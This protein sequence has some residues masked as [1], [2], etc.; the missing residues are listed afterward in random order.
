MKAFYT[1]VLMVLL[2]SAL[3]RAQALEVPVFH[4]FTGTV[5]LTAE[6]GPNVSYTDYKFEPLQID[7]TARAS[8]E[9]FFP[10][11]AKS[12]FG[13]RAFGEGGYTR[14]KDDIRTPTKFRTS[15]ISAGGGLVYGL[16]INEVVFP[17]L[18]AGGSYDWFT[19]KDDNGN[20]LSVPDKQQ[21]SGIGEL[22]FRFAIA[23][24]MSV[25]IAG[26]IHLGQKDYLDG[27]KHGS[28]NDA[29]F[30]GMVGLSIALNASKDTDHD[31]IPDDKDKCPDTPIGVR[32]DENGCPP[33]FDHDGV[34]D[35]RDKCSLTP[36]GV[37]VDENGCPLDSD[38]DGVPDYID[39]CP[40]TAAGIVVDEYGCPKDADGDGVPDYLDQCPNT[41][42]G[43]AVDMHGCPLDS[44][45]DKVPDYKDKCPN[46]PPGVQVDEFG[47][48]LVKEKVEVIREVPV[49]KEV[50]VEKEI[51]LSAGTSFATGKSV[52]LK[53]ASAVLD[54]LVTIMKENQQS[55]WII[56]GHTDNVGAKEKNKKLSLARAQAVQK[57]FVS[58]GIQK[59]RFTVRGLGSD[60]PI[61]NN[62]TEDGRSQNRRVSIIRVK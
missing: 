45:G 41:P 19:P 54:Q 44:D 12:I 15:I 5:V 25:N 1:F 13:L 57:Y 62:N 10:F 17:Y 2:T 33:D 31:G 20:S 6:A 48:P 23:Y 9:Y 28:Q 24:N 59:D 50:P 60:F 38:H 4:P 53:A 39:M 35:Y 22:G 21:F 30:S 29:Y 42:K 37:K 26:S 11:H 51:V 58:K 52:L 32:A 14:G 55:T 43:A 56:E 27:L 61:A 3:L 7:A 34:P 46:T 36:D 16:S 18:F 8:V 47:C 49:I 40:G